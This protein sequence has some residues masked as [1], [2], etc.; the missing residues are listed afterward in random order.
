MKE[1]R[2]RCCVVLVDPTQQV[3]RPQRQ[4]QSKGA[5]PGLAR[6]LSTQHL[7]LKRGGGVHH[8]LPNA[9]VE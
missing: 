7:L 1:M 5:W 8:Q 3:W 2:M 4:L 6:P 9:L